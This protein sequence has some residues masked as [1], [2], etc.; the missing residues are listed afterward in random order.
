MT[1]ETIIF[2]VLQTIPEL[3][4]SSLP[5][6]FTAKNITIVNSYINKHNMYLHDNIKFSKM[7]PEF[8]QL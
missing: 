7:K 6:I 1:L 5:Y 8:F 4:K 3:A 2:H